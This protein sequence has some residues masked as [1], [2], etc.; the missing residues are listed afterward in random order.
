MT[1]TGSIGVF[2]SVTIFNRVL[3]ANVKPDGTHDWAT[4]YLLAFGLSVALAV[5]TALLFKPKAET[6]SGE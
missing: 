3:A 4:P 5:L 6:T 2:L 1:L